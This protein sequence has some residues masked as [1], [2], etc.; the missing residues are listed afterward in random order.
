MLCLRL[1]TYRLEH[2]FLT[3]CSLLSRSQSRPD[4]LYDNPL[5]QQ[6]G[7]AARIVTSNS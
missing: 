3:S 7:F 2:T 6:T 1:L 5:R 4:I